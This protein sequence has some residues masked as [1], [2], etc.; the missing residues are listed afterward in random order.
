MINDLKKNP[1]IISAT[2]FSHTSRILFV[3]QWLED[4][5]RVHQDD[6]WEEQVLPGH[7]LTPKQL[8]WVSYGQLWCEKFHDD[9]LR[10]TIMTNPHVPGE[11]RVLV[12]LSNSPDFAKDFNCAI[13][14]PM[15][16]EKKCEVW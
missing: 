4:Q 16:P 9:A 15:N 5:K 7:N 12:P 6:Q 1:S 13:G 10:H 11:Y 8:F 2:E 14:S 3:V